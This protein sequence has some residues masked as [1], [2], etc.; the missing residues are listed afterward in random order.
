MTSRQGVVNW[1]A[2]LGRPWKHSDHWNLPC[3]LASVPKFRKLCRVYQAKHGTIKATRGVCIRL[4]VGAR[5]FKKGFLGLMGFGMGLLGLSG[6]AQDNILSF[7]P[8]SSAQP[9]I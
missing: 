3:D 6:L 8:A 4:C 5:W 9:V 2:E 7:L 1:L